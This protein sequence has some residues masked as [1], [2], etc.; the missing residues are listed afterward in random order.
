MQRYVLNV[1][2]EKC[3]N[4]PAYFVENSYQRKWGLDGVVLWKEPRAMILFQT[5]VWT[6]LKLQARSSA[7]VR[8]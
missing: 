5:T 6:F 7:A 3:K 2:L 4:A 8:Y 1:N